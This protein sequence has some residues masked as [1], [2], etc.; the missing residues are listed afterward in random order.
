MHLSKNCS[1][2][3]EES[4]ESFKSRRRSIY[5]IEEQ[6]RLRRLMQ[7]SKLWNLDFWITS[8]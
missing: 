6:V 3:F 7:K 4:A 5:D 1:N 8:C 2:Y